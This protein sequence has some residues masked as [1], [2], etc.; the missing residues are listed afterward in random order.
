[1][2]LSCFCGVMVTRDRGRQIELANGTASVN[3]FLQRNVRPT[4]Y[5]PLQLPYGTG[6]GTGNAI[7]GGSMTPCSIYHVFQQGLSFKE[8]DTR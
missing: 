3:S 4:T 2:S 1:M 7:A 6:T 5:K 8:Q